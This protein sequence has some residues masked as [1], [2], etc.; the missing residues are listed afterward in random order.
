MIG[1]YYRPQITSVMSLTH[2]ATGVVLAV[3]AFVLAAWLLALAGGSE[4]YAAFQACAGSL[5]GKLALSAFAAAL[6]YHFLNGLRHL[7]WDVGWGFEIPRVYASGYTVLILWLL[8]SAAVI[9]CG[10]NA[11]GV[12]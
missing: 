4:A 11:G 7:L 10:W 3:G 12:A 6:V 1:P 9:Y 2:R 8:L 5:L